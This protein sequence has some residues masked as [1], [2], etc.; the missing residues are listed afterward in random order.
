MQLSY[1]GALATATATATRTSKKAIGSITKTTTLHVRYTFWYISL[2]SLHDL[3]VK[4]PDGTIYGGRKHTTT[5]FS[6]S[7]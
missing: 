7:F 6:F 5:N 2:P 4:F 3:D 1:K